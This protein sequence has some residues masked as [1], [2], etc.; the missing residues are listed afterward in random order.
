MGRHKGTW[1]SFL[2][3]LWGCTWTPCLLLAMPQFHFCVLPPSSP[4]LTHP[5]P[6]T[7]PLSIPAVFRISQPA[8][9]HQP[10]PA[11]GLQRDWVWGLVT[12]EE[13]NRGPGAG[14]SCR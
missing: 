13:E 8:T 14:D 1:V 7:S 4:L 5:P 11:E 2:L 3:S 9:C 10:S 6:C 12:L